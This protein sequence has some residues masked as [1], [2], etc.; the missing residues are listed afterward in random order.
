[1]P[2]EIY[3][4][5]VHI[6]TDAEAWQHVKHAVLVLAPQITVWPLGAARLPGSC[7]R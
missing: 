1:M 4:N 5:N 7:L 3:G 2:I 6:L